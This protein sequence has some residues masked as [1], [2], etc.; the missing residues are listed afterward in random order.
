MLGCPLSY[1]FVNMHDC[2]GDLLAQLLESLSSLD[3][4]IG[5]LA[6]QLNNSSNSFNNSQYA[7]LG[8]TLGSIRSAPRPSDLHIFDSIGAPPPRDLCGGWHREYQGSISTSY[9]EEYLIARG[10]I[11]LGRSGS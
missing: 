10:R 6:C 9:R 5:G 8:V 11:R 4:G 2:L 3:R 7:H 1:I